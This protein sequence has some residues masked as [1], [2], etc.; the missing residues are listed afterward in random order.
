MIWF[1]RCC[2][3]VRFTWYLNAIVHIWRSNCAIK[4][5]CSI[6]LRNAFDLIL[7]C[8]R[9]M[10]RYESWGVVTL[11]WNTRTLLISLASRWH[12]IYLIWNRTRRKMEILKSRQER[13]YA[14]RVF[15]FFLLVNYIKEGPW[16]SIQSPR[17]ERNRKAERRERSDQVDQ[18]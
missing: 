7:I 2:S 11:S 18:S 16:W 15:F 8:P 17:K 12:E 5:S 9:D 1:W 13:W 3:N 10:E 6:Y 14:K 4:I